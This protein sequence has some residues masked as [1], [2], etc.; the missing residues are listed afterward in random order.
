MWE[1]GES[2][3]Q[4]QSKREIID[5]YWCCKGNCDRVLE[6]RYVRKYG[7]DA[8]GGW[9]D[10]SDLC[11]PLVYIRML[12]TIINQ[13][14]E[15]MVYSK[16]ALDKIKEFALTLFPYVSRQVTSKEKERIAGLM[17]IPAVFGG[18]G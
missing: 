17:R 9:E 15:G 13:Q 8:Y 11:I 12:I 6:N 14:N 2:N 1:T 7:I 16:T 4:E 18:L 3:E 5:V 10:I